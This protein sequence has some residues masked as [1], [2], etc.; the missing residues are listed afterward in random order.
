MGPKSVGDSSR[1]VVHPDGF[2]IGRSL[3][4]DWSIPEDGL[5]SRKH[6]K[7][8]PTRNGCVLTDLGSRNGTNVN[9]EPVEPFRPVEM[10]AGDM[11]LCGR[12]CFRIDFDDADGAVA[13]ASERLTEEAPAGTSPG[14]SG[15]FA[16][17]G[18]APEPVPPLRDPSMDWTKGVVPEEAAIPPNRDP[19]EGTRPLAE[20]R[21][22]S[23]CRRQKPVVDPVR[24]A[25]DSPVVDP[26]VWVCRDCRT[27]NG[28]RSGEEDLA[29]HFE[30]K[31]LL[32]RG[33]MGVVYLARHRTTGRDVALKIIDPETAATRTAIERF[34]RE[35]SVIGTLKHP[36]IVE[37]LDQG[38]DRGRLWFAMEYVSGVSL[39]TLAQANRGTYP[40]HQACRLIC[41][42]LRGL[43][44]AHSQ[45]FVHRD[46]KPENVLIG[47]TAENKLIAKISDFGLAKNYQ[48]LGGSGLTFS[49]EM[50]GTIPFMPPEQMIDFKTVKPSA[51]LY[52]SA[53]TLYYLISGTFVFETDSD[54][55]DM[56][57]MLLDHRIVPLARRRPDVPFG[58]SQLLDRCLARRP[59][60]RLPTAAA[61]RAALKV[62]S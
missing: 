53:A 61:M 13:K 41:Q 26:K 5:L 33:A 24:G 22:C 46:I 19:G 38:H 17:I 11:I 60:D 43:E 55:E 47:R 31:R 39:E 32:G 29:P 59:E 49:G 21:V 45:G 6:L 9:D 2:V 1:F 12:S 44:H 35:M 58:L 20:S 37:C 54:T 28:E 8:V 14:R 42:V 57:Q 3:E 51:D 16:A 52:A 25:L 4:C 27:E 18:A 40:Y 23:L 7:L 62:Y 15:E 30:T 34:M 48:Q 10:L 50:R 56:I 36:N